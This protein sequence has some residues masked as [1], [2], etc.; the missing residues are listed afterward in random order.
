MKGIKC[1]HYK[2]EGYR[3]EISDDEELLLCEQCNLNLGGEVFKQ[4]ALEVF[5]E[6]INKLK[7][8]IKD[9]RGV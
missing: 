1:K 2:G 4:V 9:N 3:Y 7:K 6:S 5:A 8:M